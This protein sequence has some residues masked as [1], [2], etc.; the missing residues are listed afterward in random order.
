MSPYQPP[1]VRRVNTIAESHHWKG[2]PAGKLVA[3]QSQ[4]AIGYKLIDILRVLGEIIAIA[5]VPIPEKQ[6]TTIPVYDSKKSS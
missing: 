4:A 1:T 6:Y 2:S 3:G 5:M